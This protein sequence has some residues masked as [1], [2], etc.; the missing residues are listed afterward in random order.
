MKTKGHQNS[1]MEKTQ[2]PPDLVDQTKP[3]DESRRSFT[4]SGLAVSGVVLTLASRPVLG[5]V[6]E[7]PS[8]FLSGNLSAHGTPQTCSGL[9]P[10]YWG[11]HPDKWPFPYK[12]GT[13]TASARKCSDPKYWTKVGATMFNEYFNC[14]NNGLIYAPYTMLQ[15]V[16]SG[17]GGDPYQLGA[18]IISALL[19]ARKGWTPVLTEAQVINIFNE[20]DQ[21][22]YFEP[23]AGVHWD[24]EDIVEYLKTTMS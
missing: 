10:G 17:G 5:C 4:K 12:A 7:S 2:F 23:T 19:N 21:K 16:W 24:G 3:V 1:E 15:V 18:H 20:W 6:C 22:G 14:N 9:T 13:C 8:G 11:T